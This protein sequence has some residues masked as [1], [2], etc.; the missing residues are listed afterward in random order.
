MVMNYIDAHIHAH[1]V[2]SLPG[3][4]HLFCLHRLL[5]Y[6]Q[7]TLFTQ[8]RCYVEDS[9]LPKCPCPFCPRICHV[10]PPRALAQ[11]DE[12]ISLS[13]HPPTRYRQLLRLNLLNLQVGDWSCTK[14]VCMN[15]YYYCC[16]HYLP[17]KKILA[18]T[19]KKFKGGFRTEFKH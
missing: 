5:F 7:Y 9:Q 14:Y 2:P 3:S 16:S 11:S 18:I 12:A 6:T 1:A 15:L 17:S 8:Y 10:L 4:R 13:S 19:Q